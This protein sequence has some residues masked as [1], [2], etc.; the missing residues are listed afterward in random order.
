M[1][2]PDPRI[3]ALRL[4][5]SAQL[6]D[7]K[8]FYGDLLG[9]LILD[10][11]ADALT[12]A[13][14]ETRITFSRSRAVRTAFYHIA[15]NIPQNKIL[16]AREWQRQRTPLLKTPE[17]HLDPAYPGDV[18]YFSHWNAHAVFF[19]DP[20]GNVLEYIARHD[21]NNNACGPFSSADILYASEIAFIV[22]DVPKAAAQVKQA[23]ALEQYRQS[24]DQFCVLG[25]ETGLLLIFQRGRDLGLG[26]G[27]PM[28]ARVF[29]TSAVIRGASSKT[30]KLDG[31]PYT[32]SGEPHCE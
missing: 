31:Y 13:A 29:E 8:A 1:S 19:L 10:D 5:T 22:D 9:L 7:M 18:R 21:L 28:P 32:I 11:T 25:D 15:F 16:P 14:G 24:S 26:S 12:I 30:I 6:T 4:K 20:A 27:Q 3:R 2:N 23:F 17:K